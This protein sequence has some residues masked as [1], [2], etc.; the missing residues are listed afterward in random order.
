PYVDPGLPLAVE[1][2]R[3]VTQFMEVRGEVPRTIWLANHG[4]IA[5]G[6]TPTTVLSACRMSE[7]AAQLRNQAFATGLLMRP[8]S[9][10]QIARIHTRPDEH[11]RQALLWAASQR[12]TAS[13]AE[14]SE[15]V[16]PA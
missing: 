6:E 16:G 7:K 9:S 15:A 2:A 5:L 4:L 14:P 8:L 12:N 10:A 1:I 13:E 3:A 11:Y